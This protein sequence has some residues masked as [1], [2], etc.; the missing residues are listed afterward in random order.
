MSLSDVGVM[1][2]EGESSLGCA[3]G[4]GIKPVTEQTAWALLRDMERPTATFGAHLMMNR[5]GLS[6]VL[7]AVQAPPS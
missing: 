6:M 3:A 1:S 4:S 5:K 2:P 7:E